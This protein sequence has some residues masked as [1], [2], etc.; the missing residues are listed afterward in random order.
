M[1]VV[2]HHI[3]RHLD[4]F[5][6]HDVLLVG[7]FFK[8]FLHVCWCW[9]RGVWR[10]FFHLL[11]AGL[12]LCLL[13]LP[14]C[15]PLSLRL[16][17]TMCHQLQTFLLSPRPYSCRWL[18]TR[19]RRQAAVLRHLLL[20]TARQLQRCIEYLSCLVAKPRHLPHLTQQDLNILQPY[21][22]LR[23]LILILLLYHLQFLL[24]FTS[25]CHLI[26]HYLVLWGQLLHFTF[27]CLVFE[28]GFI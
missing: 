8:S 6:M 15:L 17:I 5:F 18:Q 19:I 20:I 26:L 25:F 23:R 21:Y 9:Q 2:L 7:F 16:S 14:L 13:I 1:H 24:Y 11:N 27:Q 22:R 12:L 28:F 4:E 10:R 3:L